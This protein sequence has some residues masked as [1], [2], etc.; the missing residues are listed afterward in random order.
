MTRS[1]SPRLAAL[2]ALLLSTAPA[3]AQPAPSTADAAR[4]LYV[5]GK[6]LRRTG[7]LRG[8][9]E[10]LE[11]AHALYATPITALEV[12]RG[13]AL[14]GRLR[15]AVEVL[16]SIDRL[17]AKPDESAKAAAARAE[18]RALLPQY[19]ARA[20]RLIL[21]VE[22]EGGRVRV[23]LEVVPGDAL[24]SPWLVDPGAHRV[25]LERGELRV[26]EDVRV[27]EGE[28]RTV[29]LHLPA[30]PPVVVAPA[31]PVVV[32][33]PPVAIAP[34]PP[35]VVAP[36]ERRPHPLVYAGFS[37]AGLGL[38]T[39]AITGIVTLGRAAALKRDCRAG[40]CLPASELGVTQTLGNVST[41]SFIVGGAGLAAGGVGLL[42]GGAPAPRRAW[43]G[44]W[45]GGPVAGLGGAF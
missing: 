21:R 31:P 40:A 24:G 22:G 3:G 13:Y 9:L 15:R 38:A 42:L 8:S 27:G 36:P 2:A 35:L 41:A 43:I 32:A 4:A 29:T 19:R 26:G 17:P 16:E 6:E 44:P 12:G 45:I 25:D 14:V 33:P 34:A 23:D 1:S 5:E 28:E 18:A 11:A 7:D 39:G 30:P 37:V 20:A 10:K